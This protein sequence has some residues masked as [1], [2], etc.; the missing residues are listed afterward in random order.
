[1][2][3]IKFQM[4]WLFDVVIL[5]LNDNVV[6]FRRSGRSGSETRQIMANTTR[7]FAQAHL[8]LIWT[9]MILDKVFM[10]GFAS[11]TRPTVNYDNLS[12]RNGI[13]TMTRQTLHRR[14]GNIR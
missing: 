12:I 8:A 10:S 14:L 7:V 6:F 4:L 2:V 1:M 3:G 11:S 9:R 13:K 5:F